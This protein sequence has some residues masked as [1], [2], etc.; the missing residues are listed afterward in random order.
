M[1]IAGQAKLHLGEDD[2]TVAWLRRSIEVNRNYPL[3]HFY[4]AAALAQLGRLVEARNAVHAGLALNPG[5]NIRRFR[6]SAYSDN[7]TYLTQ[8][9]RLYDGMRKAE[10]P[11]G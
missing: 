7:P 10:V 9:E 1:G 5:F 11:D 6:A 4:L 3:G 2:E 8:R